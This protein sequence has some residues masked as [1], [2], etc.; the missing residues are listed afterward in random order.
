MTNRELRGYDTVIQD[1][2]DFEEKKIYHLDVFHD[3][4]YKL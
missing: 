3:K 1:I 4:K 2:Q